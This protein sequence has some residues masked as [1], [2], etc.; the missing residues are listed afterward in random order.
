MRVAEAWAQLLADGD[1]DGAL[2]LYAPNA[3]LHVA[4]DVAVGPRSIRGALATALPGGI[5]RPFEVR[6][7]G[8][9]VMIRWAREGAE[10]TETRLR[11]GHGEIAEQWLGS[12]TAVEP[13]SAARSPIEV[14]AQKNVSDADR[15][16]SID[17]ITKVLSTVDEPIHRVTI[18][19]DVAP[20]PAREHPARARVMLDLDGDPV[21][22]VVRA[23]TVPEAVDL[24][25]PR[26]RRRL[27]DVVE[28]RR[29]LRRRSPASSPG[30][31]RHGDPPTPRAPFHP[32][33]P[34]E[35]HVV[36]HK[37]LSAGP[38]TVDEA[39]FDLE[40]LDHDFFLFEDLASG[41][42]ALVER[43]EGG[44]YALTYLLGPTQA[45]ASPT[46]ATVDV[47]DRAAPVLT[48]AD[49]REQLDVSQAPWV[50]F[51]DPSTGRGQVLYRRHDGHYGLILPT[52]EA[53]GT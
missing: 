1:V 37:T 21:R 39:V 44:S 8:D 4:G 36:R 46:A 33:P 52:T 49:A 35:R 17:K 30:E 50:F 48:E 22:L 12:V 9:T 41:Q 5:P 47:E 2:L 6:G 38:S 32:R 11:L 31:W 16:Y 19:L 3:S 28:H 53:T 40:S 26:L 10:Q 25:E 15:Q 34:E 23:D 27:H 24:L 13:P 42:D 29:T 51:Q 43:R 45:D 20:D 7:D 18:R 14:S